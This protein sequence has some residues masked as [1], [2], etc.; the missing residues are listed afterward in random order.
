VAFD[1]TI[2]SPELYRSGI[3]SLCLL[4]ARQF[5]DYDR[6]YYRR[7]INDARLRGRQYIILNRQ[8][9]KYQ[10]KKEMMSW[11]I[12]REG[13]LGGGI[14]FEKADRRVRPFSY[15]GY[16]TIGFVNANND[17]AGLEYSFNSELAGKDGTALY[18][19]M[20]GGS[21][22]PRYDGSE[23][24]PQKGM[25][26]ETTLDVNLQD[27]TES[28]LLSALNDHGAD[29]GC[30]IVMEVESGEIKAISNLTKSR[31]HG[32]YREI[33]NY[34]VQG[35]T[36]PGSTFKLA[37]MIA[38]LEDSDLKLTDSIDTGDG[39]YK[40]YNAV[41]RDHKPG[42]Y[43]RITVRQAFEYSSNIGISKMVNNH[44]GSDPA[45]F[46]EHLG[47][48]GLNRAL[49]FQ[50]IGE[51]LPKIKDPTDP[52]WSGI[53]LPWMSIGYE[54]QLTPLQLLAFYN[55]V[56]NDGQLVTPIIVKRIRNADRIMEEFEAEVMVRSICSKRT[57]RQVQSLL[58]GVV[59][60]GTASNIKN[61][62]YRIAGKTGTAQ[63]IENGRY[64]KK[65]YTSFAG[66]FPAD[67][68]KYSCIV[69]IDSPRG[70]KQY[71]SNV[72]APVFKE[73]ADKIYSKDLEIHQP[74]AVEQESGEGIFPVIRAG[75]QEDLTR[76]CSELKIPFKSTVEDEWVRAR[77]K[78]NAVLWTTD[79][80]A[81][82]VM[83]NVTGM[84]LRDAI[85]ILENRGVRVRHT[86]RGR[87]ITQSVTPG[88]KI[89][90]KTS[91][92]LKLG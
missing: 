34:G 30:A 14:I 63:K 69:V 56:A 24:R 64:T 25:D 71:G 79:E 40:F 8:L 86:G 45:E 26:I 41:M 18:Q 89:K 35:L 53:T 58:E 31:Q 19:R 32:D 23:I 78:D 67:H 43:G 88:A 92:T 72:A 15:L 2:A 4:L 60:N 62:Y 61:P 82:G 91:I 66:Y 83:P 46:I 21:W 3:D 37:S 1:P 47:K 16:R 65:Y 39:A 7:K 42:G 52:S 59:E 5:G 36:E 49:G 74:V 54:L 77:L 22:R 76:I 28:A 57:V 29:Y 50:M 73:I 17:G 13:R 81:P 11:P 90:E 55:A 68:P 33:Y 48:M 10:V 9:V 20:A 75:K 87:V 27:V 38:L 80:I 70:F 85:F 44:F 12:F 51:G 84:T 6:T